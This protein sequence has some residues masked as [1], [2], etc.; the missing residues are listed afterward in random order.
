MAKFAVVQS[1]GKQYLVKADQEIVVQKIVSDEKTVDLEVL[2]LF[3]DENSSF[4]LGAPLLKNTIKASVMDNLKGEKIRV[5]R[6]KSKVRYRKV[7]GFR[8]QLTKL[9]VGSI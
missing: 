5:A 3:D 1:G 9:K 2:A 7:R 8:P 4:E 6:F